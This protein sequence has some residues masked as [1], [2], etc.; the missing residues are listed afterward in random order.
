MKHNIIH[1]VTSHMRL[2]FN[3]WVSAVALM[4]W[5]VGFWVT[6]DLAPAT[7]F[8]VPASALVLAIT[9]TL[10]GLSRVILL[11][12]NGA[13]GL[14]PHLRATAAG[15]SACTWAAM[16]SFLFNPGQLITSL[17]TVGAL[18]ALDIYSLWYAAEEARLVDLRRRSSGDG[19]Q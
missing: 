11:F 14:S 10:I 8:G 6:P 7:Y 15:V 19:I 3:E 18:V 4:I 9:C 13:W 16:W 17:A 2:R 12:I 1:A 5:G